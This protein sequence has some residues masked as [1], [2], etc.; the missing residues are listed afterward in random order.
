MDNYLPFIGRSSHNPSFPT[1]I[2]TKFVPA[3][4]VIPAKYIVIDESCYSVTENNQLHTFIIPAVYGVSR[5]KREHGLVY[6]SWR[7]VRVERDD[8]EGIADKRERLVTFR[9]L[10]HLRCC[11][12]WHLSSG[13]IIVRTAIGL[14]GSLQASV[15]KIS[16][17]CFCYQK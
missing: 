8:E 4:P 14:D 16:F 13:V 3:V 1:A 11:S 15:S 7:I 17:L 10:R 6:C 5:V 12:S 9:W 2:C